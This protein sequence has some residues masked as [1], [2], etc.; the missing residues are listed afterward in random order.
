MEI[1]TPVFATRELTRLLCAPEAVPL[2]A[3]KDEVE[4]HPDGLIGLASFL[5]RWGAPWSEAAS[6]IDEFRTLFEASEN[7]FGLQT[8]KSLR[9]VT[10]ATDYR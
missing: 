2:I 7:D 4:F 8:I 1:G 9:N 6:T 3:L 10:D 5:L